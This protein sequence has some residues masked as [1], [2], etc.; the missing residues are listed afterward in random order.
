MNEY[1]L[2]TRPLSL[3][4]VYRRAMPGRAVLA[5]ES[6]RLDV[7]QGVSPAYRSVFRN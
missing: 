5:N 3:I 4:R 1:L 7:V 6:L 2:G